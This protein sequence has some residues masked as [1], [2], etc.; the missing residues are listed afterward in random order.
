MKKLFLL[1]AACLIIMP[2]ASMAQEEMP[3]MGPPE[4]MKA[5]AFLVGEWE[6]DMEWLMD[7]TQGW[8]PS[9]GTC[10]Y[11]YI[12]DGAVMQM[13]FR[14]EMMGMPFNGF[15][16]ETYDREN[17]KWQSTWMD[18]MGARITLM[19]G[20][21]ANNGSV[22][23][24]NEKYLGEAYDMRMSTS[25]ETEK[26]FEWIMEQSWDGGKTWKETGRASYKKKK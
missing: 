4:E 24:G 18:N 17:K 11:S 19:T 9:K 16:F 14:S 8:V 13:D 10:T 22:F 23:F 1:I 20:T 7:T 25:N 12:L 26:S 5:L 6:A 2:M 3:P 15:A 21:R